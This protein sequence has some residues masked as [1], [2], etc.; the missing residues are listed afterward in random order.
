MINLLECAIL[1]TRKKKHIPLS[2]SIRFTVHVRVERR[3]SCA[4]PVSA[5]ETSVRPPRKLWFK[6]CSSDDF[7][8]NNI[9]LARVKICCKQV[10]S[11]LNANI[12]CRAHMNL[13]ARQQNVQLRYLRN[14]QL[15]FTYV[16]DYMIFYLITK[17]Q[18]NRKPEV[19]MF[20]FVVIRACDQKWILRPGESLR[21]PYV[22]TGRWDFRPFEHFIISSNIWTRKVGKKNLYNF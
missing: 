16:C 6:R 10:L 3:R 20:D 8:Y 18:K 4:C 14:F 1:N 15:K 22:S 5:C 2:A 17:L 19:Y 9:W 21:R 7:S 12:C 13:I 11:I